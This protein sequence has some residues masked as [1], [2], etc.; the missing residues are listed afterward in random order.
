MLLE[1]SNQENQSLKIECQQ[2]HEDAKFKREELKE[3]KNKA[4]LL[5]EYPFSSRINKI[6]SLSES[7]DHIDANSVRILLLEEQNKEIRELHTPREDSN[8]YPLHVSH[9][10]IIKF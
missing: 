5:M 6:L 9:Q 1:K 10:I 3:E 2:L 8:L 4:R 7:R